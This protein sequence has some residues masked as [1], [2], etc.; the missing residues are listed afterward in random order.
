LAA[1]LRTAASGEPVA[2]FRVLASGPPVHIAIQPVRS[3]DRDRLRVLAHRSPAMILLAT[4]AEAPAAAVPLKS[5][6]LANVY[7]LTPAEVRVA[8]PAADGVSLTAIADALQLT[9]N[10]VKTHL[11]RVYSKTQ[12]RRQAELMRLL[13]DAAQ[14]ASHGQHSPP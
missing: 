14:L 10:T 12:V 4:Q 9:R 6:L 11:K 13:S 7:G 8:L 5:R 1:A 3:L 2:A